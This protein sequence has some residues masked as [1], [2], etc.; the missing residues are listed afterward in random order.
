MKMNPIPEM[1]TAEAEEAYEEVT[2]N[3]TS[4]QMDAIEQNNAEMIAQF[5]KMKHARELY[6]RLE[7]L[8][9]PRT[10][11]FV[12]DFENWLDAAWPPGKQ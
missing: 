10:G 1:D 5:P 4:T 12:T 7:V 2:R 11:D 9:R 3:L 6:E 8:R